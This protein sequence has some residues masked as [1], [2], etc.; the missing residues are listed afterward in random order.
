MIHDIVDYALKNHRKTA[1]LFS[2]G[3][4]STALYHLLEPYLET[5]PNIY[6]LHVDT[7]DHP[8]EVL[9]FVLDA[10]GHLDNFILVQTDK[11]AWVEENGYPSDVVPSNF[12]VFGQSYEKPREFMVS[13]KYICCNANIWAPVERAVRENGITCIL[14]GQRDEESHGDDAASGDWKKGIQRLFP[15]QN[16]TQDELNSFLKE[17]GTWFPRFE[18]TESSID[19]LTCT[20]FCEH[21]ADRYK[22]LQEHYPAEHAEVQRRLALI[23]DGIAENM[24]G[25][26]RI[27]NGEYND[28]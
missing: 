8:P 17:K 28:I 23:R 1:F 27:I 18:L 7:G 3:K 12:T 25:I 19:C 6:V 5:Q 13:D 24:G 10:V 11:N 16:W 4:D 2:G 26:N 22:Y 21:A 9:D 14:T 15:L 20:A